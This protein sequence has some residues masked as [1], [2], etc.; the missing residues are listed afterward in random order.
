MPSPS[1]RTQLFG[2]KSTPARVEVIPRPT[3]WRLS[4][5]ALSLAIGWGIIPVVALVPPHVPWVLGGF[6]GGIYFAIRYWRERYTLV[7][8]DTTCPKCGAPL[9]QEK[10][11]RL[12]LPHKLHCDQC[13][14]NPL[15]EVDV[16]GLEP[17][18]AA[19]EAAPP[20]PHRPPPAADEPP[21][22]RPA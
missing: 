7:R 4:H 14:Q 11:T 17:G 13:Q 12:G 5:A 9:R 21:E 18:H 16:S 10:P 3:S 8:L 19:R 15:L 6:F 20:P 22:A 1:A 2:F